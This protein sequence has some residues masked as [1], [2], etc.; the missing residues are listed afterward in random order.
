MEDKEDSIEFLEMKTA[1]SKVK[2]YATGINAKLD[3]VKEKINELEDVVMKILQNK[4]Q[5][6]QIFF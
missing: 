3:L 5:G 2:Q 1:M 6:K 4:T